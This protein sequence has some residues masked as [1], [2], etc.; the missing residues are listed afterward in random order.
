MNTV[1][2]NSDTRACSVC[3]T[4]EATVKS[5]WIVGTDSHICEVYPKAVPV[6]GNTQ[7]A[8]LVFI[9]AIHHS[10]FLPGKSVFFSPPGRDAHLLICRLPTSCLWIWTSQLYLHPSAL[11][12]SSSTLSQWSC[13]IIAD[14]RCAKKK[15]K[16]LHI[17]TAISVYPQT[18]ITSRSWSLLMTILRH[19][20]TYNRAVRSQNNKM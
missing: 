2:T 4:L 11:H 18:A 6:R 12:N 7:S 5:Y 15:K 13:Q 17:I 3:L 1:E 14:E 16:G 8:A 19:S 20:S 10:L 9:T